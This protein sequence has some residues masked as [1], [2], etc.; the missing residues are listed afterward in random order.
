MS[1]NDRSS[2][3]GSDPLTTVIVSLLTLAALAGTVFCLGYAV[4]WLIVF[5]APF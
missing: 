4:W 3:G 1:D 2:S 5:W